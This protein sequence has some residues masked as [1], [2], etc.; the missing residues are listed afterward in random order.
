MY[1]TLS[2]SS[3]NCLFRDKSPS[4]KLWYQILESISNE[5]MLYPKNSVISAGFLREN[6]FK[7]ELIFG[8]RYHNWAAFFFNFPKICNGEGSPANLR[9]IVAVWTEI[10]AIL[11]KYLPFKEKVRLRFL[12]SVLYTNRNKFWYL[13]RRVPIDPSFETN[14]QPFVIPGSNIDFF[15]NGLYKPKCD[16]CFHNVWHDAEHSRKHHKMDH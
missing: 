13:P 9:M 15:Y 8:L 6:I 3:K 5:L 2:F 7:T 14:T 4:L 10:W 12:L 16:T 11:E 1:T